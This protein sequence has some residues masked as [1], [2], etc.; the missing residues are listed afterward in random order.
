MPIELSIDP[1]PIWIAAALTAVLF[2]HAALAKF[3][4][5]ALLQQHL[6]TYGVPYRALGVAA[7]LLPTIELAAAA[8]TLTPLRPLG[9]AFAA[10]LLLC[11]A[12]AMAWH[13]TRGHRLDCGCGGDAL[14]VSWALVARNLLLAALAAV[15]TL[16]PAPRAMPLAD[17]AVVAA[18]VMLGVVLYAAFNQVLRHLDNAQ[19]RRSLGKA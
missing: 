15:A 18:A 13:C 12:A 2:A 8:L 19:A 4:D 9:A 16:P 7:S 11:Y 5:L 3:A 17:F 14:Q 6:F 1:L 10:A